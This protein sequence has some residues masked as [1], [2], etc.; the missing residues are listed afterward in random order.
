MEQEEILKKERE[1]AKVII[2][3]N[4]LTNSGDAL[5]CKELWDID[6]GITLCKNCHKL[7][8]S[9]AGKINSK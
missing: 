5:K 4:K 9:Y 2:K 8:D 1:K 7:T 6:N 3:E